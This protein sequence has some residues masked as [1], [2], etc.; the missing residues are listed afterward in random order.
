[1]K[2][3]DNS[4]IHTNSNFILSVCLLILLDT[5]FL[6]PSLHCNTSPHGEILYTQTDH[7][8]QYNMTHAYFI[9]DTQGYRHTLRICNT[10]CFSTATVLARTRLNVTFLR[11]L[12]LLFT[13]NKT[14]PLPIYTPKI[15]RGFPWDRISFPMAKGLWHYRRILA[16]MVGWL[17]NNE[18]ERISEKSFPPGGTNLQFYC[19]NLGNQW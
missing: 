19:R 9:M 4:K 7:R 2:E 12:P 18:F 6:R 17:T 16:S 15:P 13:L 5:L 8:W 1:L 3:C 10:Y 11:T 14:C